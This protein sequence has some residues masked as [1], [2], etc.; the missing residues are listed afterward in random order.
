[1]TPSP[2]SANIDESL[3]EANPLR[4]IERKENLTNS[5]NLAWLK[6]W[7]PLSHEL[8]HHSTCDGKDTSHDLHL[9]KVHDGVEIGVVVIGEPS[10]QS[11][12]APRGG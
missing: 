11:L 1:M 3:K 4:I 5:L 12:R 7:G 9:L 10:H 6:G 2:Y 8:R